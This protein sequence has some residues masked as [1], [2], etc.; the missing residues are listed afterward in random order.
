VGDVITAAQRVAVH[1]KPATLYGYA[2]SLRQLA[3][4]VAGIKGDESRFDY[5]PGGGME[6]WRAQ[7]DAVSLATLTPRVVE[8]AVAAY[9][10]AR[11]ASGE[12]QQSAAALLRQARG[13]WSRK[14]ARLLP[15]E[16]LPNPF[17][18]V[19]IGQPRAPKYVAEFDS[20]TLVADARAELRDADPEAW[21]AFLL[22]L[23]GG[24]R[25]GEADALVWANVDTDRGVLRILSGKTVDS[26]GEVP[27]GPETA[28]E[29]GRLRKQATGP[30][31]LDGDIRPMAKD[32]RTYRA[33]ATFERLTAWLRAH[34]VND[35]KP[36]HALRKEAGSLVNALAGIHAA[37]RFLRHADIGITAAHYADQRQRAIVPV[38]ERR[39][40]K[41]G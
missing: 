33:E 26:I 14:F 34:G 12:V 23:G 20:A 11:G 30:H 1:V 13:F 21:K 27:L 41:A 39:E 25:K 32:R 40:G 2:A 3:A 18:G 31:V 24:L 9:V 19:V 35:R 29:F 15:F 5:R 17:E 37:S 8:N 28:S 38:F 6:R 10:K 7:V 36:L 16:D 22:L 4:M